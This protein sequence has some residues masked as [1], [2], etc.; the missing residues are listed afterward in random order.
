MNRIA[1]K[2]KLKEGVLDEYKRRHDNI[3]PE[4]LDLLKKMEI[5][6][7]SI[8]VDTDETT[9]FAVQTQGKNF[10]E[11]ELKSHPIMSKWW[12]YMADLMEVE[13]DNSPKAQVLQQVFYMD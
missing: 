6:D 13:D 7:Y 4:L 1:F 10:D 2:M 3:W 12:N 8:F 11:S 5:G 9:L